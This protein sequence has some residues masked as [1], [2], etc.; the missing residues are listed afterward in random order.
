MP[1]R[2]FRQRVFRQWFH[3]MVPLATGSNILLNWFTISTSYSNFRRIGNSL[4]RS[5]AHRPF[6]HSLKIDHFNER[7][8]AICSDCSR[9]MRDCEQIAKDAHDKRASMSDSLR[10]LMIKEQM[11][12]SLVFFGA[13][14]LFA[15]KKQ[16]IGSKKIELTCIC[17]FVFK[18]F[19]GS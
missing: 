16:A 9:Q 4:I 7:L 14:R 13:N 19:S 1:P 15:H 2:D 12:E 11:S 17:I 5:F 3:S 10:V 6:A 8:W 18:S